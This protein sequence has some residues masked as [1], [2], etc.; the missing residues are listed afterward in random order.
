MILA[1]AYGELGLKH[2]RVDI[3]TIEQHDLENNVRWQILGAV[4]LSGT[5]QLVLSIFVSFQGHT[6]NKMWTSRRRASVYRIWALILLRD[7]ADMM[8]ALGLDRPFAK[9]RATCVICDRSQLGIQTDL[10]RKT[11][12][13]NGR[14]FSCVLRRRGATKTTWHRI[15]L[16]KSDLF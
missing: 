6:D 14:F 4:I 9:T 16:S 12:V 7:S 15:H 3:D 10:T 8:T 13:L 2:A 1:R 5:I 11:V